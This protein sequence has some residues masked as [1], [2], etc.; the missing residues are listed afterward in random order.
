MFKRGF[1]EIIEASDS[2]AKRYVKDILLGRIIYRDIWEAFNV[3]DMGLVR[4][5]SELLLAAPG[6]VVNVNSLA[7]EL[8]K[9]RKTVS[10]V[11][12]YLEFSFVLKM[13]QN[14]RGPKL[15]PSRKDQ[16]AY[17]THCSFAPTDD[18]TLLA[19]TLVCNAVET[20]GYWTS[21]SSE[22]DFLVRVGTN[23]IPVSVNLK[24]SLTDSDLAGIKNF[25]RRFNLMR[26]VVVT[27][28]QRGR[29][30]WADLIPLHIFLS[31][32]EK[33]LTPVEL[34]VRIHLR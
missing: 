20:L 13:F 32:P 31:N 3:K 28:E 34:P 9:A 30:K 12:D 15:T 25:C 4:D 17:P 10:N 6:S 16:K 27:K 7:D 11:L 24:D 19:K 29:M 26:G 33:Y 1:P 5:L 22:V 18:E 23:T 8:D 21:G 14:L 2:F